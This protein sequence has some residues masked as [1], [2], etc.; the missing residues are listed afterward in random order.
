MNFLLLPFL[1][2]NVCATGLPVTD[3]VLQGIQATSLA[4]NKL[5]HTFMQI[6]LVQ[7]AIMIKNNILEAE[8]YY[9]YID[10]CSKHRGGLIG[11]YSDMIKLQLQA[12]I[13]QDKMALM[14]EATTVTGANAVDDFM[15]AMGAGA[16]AAVQSA[17]DAANS[18]LA[19]QVSGFNAFYNGVTDHAVSAANNIVR[20]YQQKKSAVGQAQFARNV[21]LS[22][23]VTTAMS[24]SNENIA[25]LAKSLA[26]L[27]KLASQGDLEDRQ[28][29]QVNTS[30][31]SL[32]TR[33]ALEAYKMLNIQ[34]TLLQASLNEQTASQAMAMQVQQDLAAY[35][36]QQGQQKAKYS[37]T[38]ADVL[39]EFRRKP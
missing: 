3:P 16:V 35:A 38:A 28:Y 4:N 20:N 14:N 39:R 30:M 23:A 17:G 25:A 33:I 7:D 2:A 24:E 13:E 8:S 34:A 19:G 37:H 31:G 10:K 5:F 1:A 11:Y 32:N 12:M 6:Q 26:N 22:Q 27:D 29:E 18:A 21:T 15:G 36:T 9:N